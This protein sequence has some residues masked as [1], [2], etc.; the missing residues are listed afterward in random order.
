MLSGIE[1]FD[2]FVSDHLNSQN[3]VL[4]G[5]PKSPGFVSG[6]RGISRFVSLIVGFNVGFN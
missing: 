3:E 6:L 5:V 4:I 2:F 1:I